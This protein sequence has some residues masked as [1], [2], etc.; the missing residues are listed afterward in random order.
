MV[1]RKK[2][3]NKAVGPTV[4]PRVI[5]D[6]VD[7]R[8]GTTFARGGMTIRRVGEPRSAARPAVPGTR[9]RP[10]ATPALLPRPKSNDCSGCGH[11]VTAQD[12]VDRVF[13]G[14]VEQFKHVVCP[15]PR[16]RPVPQ[17]A[18]P[19]LPDVD[20]AAPGGS[21]SCVDCGKP[22][23]GSRALLRGRDETGRRLWAHL[24]C[25]GQVPPPA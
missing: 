21:P 16:E 12:Y 1:D 22:L 13:V 6:F 24:H 25:P 19:R 2:P 7:D 9:A 8:Q 11:R 15:S 18:G 3:M 14:G 5:G 20:G 10:P 23:N 4:V 17:R